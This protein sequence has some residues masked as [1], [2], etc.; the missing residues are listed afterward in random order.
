MADNKTLVNKLAEVKAPRPVD[1]LK[2]LLQ[3]KIYYLKRKIIFGLSFFLGLVI[4]MIIIFL[5]YLDVKKTSE[6]QIKQVVNYLASIKNKTTDIESKINDVKKYKEIWKNTK[7]SEKNFNGANI[8]D[9]NKEFAILSEKHHIINSSLKISVPE[10]LKGGV[11]DRTTINVS[12]S[13]VSISFDA[14]TDVRAIEFVKDFTNILPGYIVITNFSV[15]K[16][17]DTG[18]TPTDLVN[19][20]TGKFISGVSSKLEFSWYILKKKSSLGKS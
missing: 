6:A 7:D 13:T 10:I 17:V 5:Y 14:L 3:K 8:N 9:I 11:Y 12:L 15:K 4:L 19:I 20:S 1:P 18:F 2:V 16:T